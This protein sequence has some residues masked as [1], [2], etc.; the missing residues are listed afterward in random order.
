M[1]RP[2]KETPDEINQSGDLK[3][4]KPCKRKRLKGENHSSFSNKT[5]KCAIPTPSIKG[6]REKIPYAKV[7]L[8]STY[9]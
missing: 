4:Q 5:Q 1:Q 3:R 9:D 6:L 7:W 2:L 8:N